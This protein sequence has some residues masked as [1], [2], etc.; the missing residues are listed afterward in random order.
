[1]KFSKWI[2]IAFMA[3]AMVLLIGATVS[4]VSCGEE[5][6]V[7]DGRLVTYNGTAE[8]VTIPP[9]VTTIG[10]EAFF[11]CSFIQEII[12]PPTLE[13]IESGAFKPCPNA[14]ISVSKNHPNFYSDNGNLMR[15]ADKRLMWAN[16]DGTAPSYAESIEAGAYTNV[17]NTAEVTLPAGLT[18][19]SGDAL[20]DCKFTKLTISGDVT[21]IAANAF[22]DA[23]ISQ[24]HVTSVPTIGANAFGDMKADVV[25][26]DGNVDCL[27]ANAFNDADVDNVILGGSI[28]KIHEGALNKVKMTS[29]TVPFVGMRTGVA[30]EETR[31]T[32]RLIE[33]FGTEG[34]GFSYNIEESTG[35]RIHNNLQSIT[36][37][38]GNICA[39]AF[40]W[41]HN[42]DTIVLR[43]GVTGVMGEEAFSGVDSTLTIYVGAGVEGFGK[44]AFW[45]TWIVDSVVIN[46][47]GTEQQ[48][49][50]LSFHTGE[51]R[52]DWRGKSEVTVN[53][54]VPA[55]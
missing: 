53:F 8:V 36:V 48:W 13:T 43:D 6:K 39:S 19:L 38:S 55:P 24:I 28:T 29:L 49:N 37:L 33:I 46:Y 41:C 40:G 26:L 3:V 2:S 17:V 44:G 15:R 54:C 21:S 7:R 27:E 30:G 18:F 51:G 16:K 22:K 5:F 20:N 45:R 14:T 23:K 1:M 11:A 25:Y 9:E 52:D 35:R 34:S 4:M 12:L 47:S 32:A 31:S 50:Q 42:V 10:S